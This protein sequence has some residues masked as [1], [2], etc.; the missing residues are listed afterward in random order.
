MADSEKLAVADLF[1]QFQSYFYD[2]QFPGI[3]FCD[4]F[5]PL[6]ETCEGGLLAEECAEKYIKYITDD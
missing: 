2:T 3:T 1:M 5:C 6:A 4:N